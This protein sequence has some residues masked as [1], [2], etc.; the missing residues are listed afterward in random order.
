MVQWNP[1]SS[2]SVPLILHYG[3]AALSVATAAAFGTRSGACAWQVRDE[4]TIAF[5]NHK[6]QVV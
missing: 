4:R 6:G 5:D 3:F 1:Q 2:L